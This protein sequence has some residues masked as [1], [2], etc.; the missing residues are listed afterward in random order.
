MSKGLKALKETAIQTVEALYGK[1]KPLR[2][3]KINELLETRQFKCIEKELKALEIIKERG[4]DVNCII[5]G[6]SLGKYNS[7]KTHINL[8]KEEFDLLKEELE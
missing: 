3:H 5:S 2:N 8:T 6:W 4:V 1:D 7:Y